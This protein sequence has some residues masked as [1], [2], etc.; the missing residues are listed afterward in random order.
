MKT[1]IEK[2]VT[3]AL[4]SLKIISPNRSEA[5]YDILANATITGVS[6]PF[7][8]PQPFSGVVLS[9]E[10]MG[11]IPLSEPPKNSIQYSLENGRIVARTKHGTFDVEVL[12]PRGNIDFVFI[13]LKDKTGTT[14]VIMRRS[15]YYA[16]LTA[17]YNFNAVLFEYTDKDE[18]EHK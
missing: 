13:E 7:E 2:Q 15:A 1:K 10:G 12:I 8:P 3:R 6:Q 14:C 11:I 9:K 4:E 5:V 16:F 18:V 17:L